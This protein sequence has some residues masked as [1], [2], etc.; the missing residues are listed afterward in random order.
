MKYMPI[1]A[2]FGLSACMQPAALP[3]PGV[4]TLSCTVASFSTDTGNA[5]FI[6]GNS[7]KRFTIRSTT[8]GFTSEVRSDTFANSTTDFAIYNIGDTR[9]S[10][11]ER[12]QT[13]ASSLRFTLE[14]DRASSGGTR[15]AI[16]TM[17]VDSSTNE[18]GYT[19]NQ[20]ILDCLDQS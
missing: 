8:D 10:A 20:W 3:N 17:Q 11:R 9:I 13:D 18:R 6:S 16:Q 7:A 19:Q 2:L 14:I 12:G 15:R 5:D 4:P 1:I